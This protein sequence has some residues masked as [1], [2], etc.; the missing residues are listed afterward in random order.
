M[1]PK[2]KRDRRILWFKLQ[3]QVIRLWLWC[4]L[5][6]AIVLLL[7]GLK[8]GI[9]GITAYI[10][11]ILELGVALGG[12]LLLVA[13]DENFGGDNLIRSKKIWIRKRKHAFFAGLGIL[14]FVERI[15]EVFSV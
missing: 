9:A 2:E 6:V 5:G 11:S 10:P 15:A 3:V 12:S 1:T 4:A 13:L 8:N 7:P 14:I